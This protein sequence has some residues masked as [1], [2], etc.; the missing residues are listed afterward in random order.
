MKNKLLIWVFGL[1]LLVGL[2][3][4][5]S[6]NYGL[7]FKSHS[8]PGT[9]RTTLSLDENS[10]FRVK[11]DFIIEFQ[12]WVRNEPDFGA[13]LHLCTN[14]NQFLHFVFAAGENNKNFP[15][16]VFNEGMFAINTIIEKGKWIPVSLHLNIKDNQIDLRYDKKDTTMVVPLRGTKDITVMFGKSPY[17]SSD[18]APMDVKNVKIICDGKLMRNWELGKHNDD[19]CLDS[20]EGAVALASFPTWLI[21]NHIEWKKIHSEKVSGRMDV[22]FN[23]RDAKFYFVQP[24][25]IRIL[26]DNTGN[27]SEVPVTGG[28]PAMEYP[29]HLVY[30]T[31]T[32]RIFSYS[33]HEKLVSVLSVEE[34]KWSL[35]ERHQAEPRYYNHARTFNPADSSF[36]LF[37]GYGFYQYRNNLY[38]LKVGQNRI[39]EVAYTPAISP[40][41]SSATAIV[42]DE[43]YIFGGRGNKQGKQE[44]TAHFNYELCAINLKTGQSR[45]LWKKEESTDMLLMASSMYFAPSD[46]S[47]YAV[48]MKTGGV[49]WKISMNDSVWTEVSK[50]IHNDLVYQDCDFSF[51]SSPAH[52]KFYLVMDKILSDRSHDVT[53]YSIN[54]PLLNDNE[55]IQNVDS[56][57]IPFWAWLSGG[58]ALL[59]VAVIILLYRIKH[60]DRKK[61]NQHADSGDSDVRLNESLVV[62][63]DPEKEMVDMAAVE[64]FF[65]RSR[66]AISLLGTFNVRDKE[67][68]DITGAFTPRLK[69]LLIMLVLYT[70]RNSQGILTKKATEILWSDKEEEAGRNNRNVT[71]RKLRV[72]LERV[73]DMEVISDAG[74]LRIQWGK[75]V[76]C[77]YKTALDCIHSFKENGE[78]GDN[79]LLNRIFEVLLYGPLLSNTI[80][81]WLDEFKDAFS[82][83]SID[84]LRNL[85]EIHQHHQDTVL[86]MADILFL[87]D[88]L[89]EE[90]LAAKCNVL[91]LQGKKGLAKSVYDRFCKEY[92]DSLGEEYKI[93]LCHLQN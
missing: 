51:Y 70:E 11:N 54:T 88:P 41:Y 13:I 18:V 15:A 80:V 85:L 86:R 77:D 34:G 62:N 7:H 22:A 39:E 29:D 5:A 19:I 10:P 16:L 42:G 72:L 82:S 27:V 3:T 91:Y 75:D 69:S 25:K 31:L 52:Q 1:F 44:F 57:S 74:F 83:L 12:M 66:S 58:I 64:K 24:D 56:N 2:E 38:R 63:E 8:V 87:H 20:V 36:Y 35:N 76:F 90:A 93:P 71:L 32:G 49:L 92:R 59:V 17:F 78:Q 73:G 30:D 46:S 14:E 81:D 45:R 79:E 6:T 68:N 47:F 28:Y 84:L 9:E 48:S 26:D 23:A 43:L 50:P 67:G 40:R 53:V 61:A 4:L 21:D 65:D 33:L 55:I 37:G 60:H 89:S